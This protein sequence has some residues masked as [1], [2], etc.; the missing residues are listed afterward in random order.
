[1]LRAAHKGGAV[2]GVPTRSSS[3]ADGP[4]YGNPA[5]EGTASVKKCRNGGIVV[6]SAPIGSRRA[7]SWKETMPSNGQRYTASPMA[8]ELSDAAVRADRI[9]KRAVG[10]ECL[11]GRRGWS[12]CK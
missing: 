1:M 8:A 4:E 2:S 11:P 12:N 10:R 5:E 9:R 7:A 6:R 3:K